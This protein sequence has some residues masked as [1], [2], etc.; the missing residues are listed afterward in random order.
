MVFAAILAGGSGTRVGGNIPKQF[1][2]LGNAPVI[3]ETINVFLKSKKVDLIYISVNEAWESYTKD[4]LVQYYSDSERNRM[5]I[6]LGGKERMMTFL[7]VIYVI[8]DTYGIRKEDI[9]LSHDAVRPF[10]TEAIIDDCLEKTLESG[11]A[12]ATVGSADTVY[13]SKQSGYLT[14][15]Y[16]RKE[17]F[18]GQTPQGCRMDL[19]YEVISSYSEEELL[20]MTGTSQLFI[21]KNIPVRMSLGSVSNLKITTLNDVEFLR[22]KMQGKES[23]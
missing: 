1:L 2:T 10:V 9:V 8:R 15:T 21:N 5:K 14:K 16:N 23:T 19:M 7:N 3:I 22:F 17:I 11:V 12:M 13:E 6:V 18:V 20:S 4:L